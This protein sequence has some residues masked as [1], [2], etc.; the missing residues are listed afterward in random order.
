MRQRIWLAALA[1]G[2]LSC[3]GGEGL[4]DGRIVDLSHAYDA[5]TI[6]WPSD[7]RGFEYETLSA[8]RDA[9]GDWY[10]AGRF[11]TAEHGGTHMDAPV[12]F[13]EGKAG[14][15]EVPLARLV[16]RGVLVDV[17]PS[18]AAD[19][20]YRVRIQDLLDWEREHGRIP[21]GAIVLLRTGWAARFS[22]RARYL[23]TTAVG[24]EAVTGLHFP[25]LEPDAARWLAEQR[26]IAA[27]GLDTPSIDHGPSRHFESHRI[28]AAAEIPIFENL[29][30]LAELPARG[31]SVVAL[32]MKI[33][34]GT[35]A[36]LRAI[37]IVP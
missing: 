9:T 21:D 16:G 31:F 24:P 20:D 7:E 26:E 10:A 18:C 28:L 33:A 37:A 13:A 1:L 4:P 14:V 12:H 6:Y 15:D 17:G 8:G 36:P 35:G 27:V 29:A 34:R 23:G 32:P 11:A 25:G 30:S 2:A 5:G 22:D 3:G 19:P